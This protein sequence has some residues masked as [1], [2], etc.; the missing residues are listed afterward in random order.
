MGYLIQDGRL[1]TPQGCL[2]ADLRTNGESICEIGPRL[3]P[4]NDE[5]INAAGC[6]VFPGFIDTHTHLAL[7]VGTAVSADDFESG[8]RA[9]ILGG[10]TTI[11][12]FATQNKGEHL[13]QALQNWHEKAAPGSYC[14]YGFHMAITDWNPQTAQEMCEMPAAGVTSYKMYMA[15]AALRV[16]DA[17]IYQA[18]QQAKAQG[19][20]IGFHCENGHLVDALIEREKAQGHLA[21]SAHPLSRPPA[22]EAEAIYRLLTTAELAGATVNIVHLSSAQ[23]LEVVREFRKKGLTVL[24]ETCPQ[25]LLLEESRYSLPGFEGAKYVMSPPLRSEQDCETLWQALAAG[26]IQT[27]GTDH[28]PFPTSVKELGRHDFSKIPNGIPGLQH[29]GLLLYSYGVATGRLTPG[30]MCALLAENPA[31]LFGLYPQKGCLCVGSHADITIVD[32]NA[33]GQIT[34]TGQAHRVD[35][36]PYEGFALRCQIPTVLLRGKRVVHNGKA[37]CGMSG[38]YVRR[39]KACTNL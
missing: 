18:L 36:T 9:A 12:D 14:D 26:E 21:P 11:L 29:R 3:A 31:K 5:V 22:V 32:P 19:S 20:I 35:Y 34:A 4:G 10:T 33:T 13:P 23:G 39:G 2:M 8:S 27:I 28:C 15:Y 7:D 6:L 30:Q 17:E 38:Q 1:V 24:V 37:V 25:Y 16:N